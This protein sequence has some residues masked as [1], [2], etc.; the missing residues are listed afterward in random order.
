DAGYTRNMTRGLHN[1]ADTKTNGEGLYY[2]NGQLIVGIHPSVL[3][4][5]DKPAMETVIPKPGTPP[6]KGQ[7]NPYSCSGIGEP[8]LVKPQVAV[9]EI[10]AVNSAGEGKPV[11]PPVRQPE[12][13]I[14]ENGN[15]SEK[16]KTD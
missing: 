12:P 15:T 16:N 14:N 6:A 2:E 8:E 13:V 5:P 7:L 9:K 4:D 10:P 11:A 3:P 1:D